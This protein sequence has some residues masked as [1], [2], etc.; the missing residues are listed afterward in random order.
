[1]L[2]MLH[3][4]NRFSRGEYRRSLLPKNEMWWLFFAIKISCRYKI[5]GTAGM[6]TSKMRHQAVC[7]CIT[8]SG[9]L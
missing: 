4:I 1:M 2:A 6:C 7:R 5:K 9:Y 8:L 3:K